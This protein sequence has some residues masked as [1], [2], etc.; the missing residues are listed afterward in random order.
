[1]SDAG[2][3]LIQRSGGGPNLFEPEPLTS[4]ATIAALWKKEQIDLA[5]LAR[6]R[7]V[8]KWRH[9]RLAKHFGITRSTVRDWIRKINANP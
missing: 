1:M 8:E 9:E 4:K 2:S 6:L 7:W 5:E 3:Y